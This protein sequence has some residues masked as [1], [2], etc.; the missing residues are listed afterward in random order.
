M[1]NKI[2]KN[3]CFLFWQLTILIILN[4][5]INT[6]AT[7]NPNY[8]FTINTKKNC[9]KIMQNSSSDKENIQSININK[10]STSINNFVPKLIQLLSFKNTIQ[11]ETKLPNEEID[12]ELI[13][14]LTTFKYL[15]EIRQKDENFCAGTFKNLC[16]DIFKKIQQLSE[17][18]NMLNQFFYVWLIE[19]NIPLKSFDNLILSEID[20][21]TDGSNN[22]IIIYL[23]NISDTKCFDWFFHNRYLNVNDIATIEMYDEKNNRGIIQGSILFLLSCSF[24]EIQIEINSKQKLTPE[25]EKEINELSNKKEK[26]LKLTNHIIKKYLTEIDINYKGT[27]YGEGLYNIF[28]EVFNNIKY[29]KHLTALEI[30]KLIEKWDNRMAILINCAINNKIPKGQTKQSNV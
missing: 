19:L 7:E 25:E 17:S 26:L 9:N 1:N 27:F 21:L 16:K 4:G 3:I 30:A 12:D 13:E 2:K 11:Q 6:F 14:Q 24:V 18:E 8:I 29:D 20:E 5:F 22:L 28:P 10:S 15:Y 23:I